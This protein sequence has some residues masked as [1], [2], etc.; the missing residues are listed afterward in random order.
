MS[1]AA[2]LE[3]RSLEASRLIEARLAGA[4]APCVTSSFQAE[5]V[6]LVHLLRQQRPEI[7][8][9]F[10]DTVHH[11]GETYAYRDQLAESWGLN[12]INLRAGEPSP[13][14]WQQDT[15]ACCARHK[16]GPLFAALDG[17]D[18][19]FT[20]LRR[21]Q[22]P[23]R[24]A[25]GEVEPF[26]LPTGRV[27]HQGQPAG[28]LVDARGVGLREAARHPAAAALRAGLHQH[29]LPAVHD[30][31]GRSGQRAVGALGG[32]EAGVRDSHP[33]TV[34]DDRTNSWRR[35]PRATRLSGRARR[36]RPASW[37]GAAGP[38]TA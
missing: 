6:V 18:A 8:V 31:A 2:T 32:P 7:P 37:P 15:T 20:G 19:W 29:R 35:R 30:A 3:A 22:S 38:G 24:A 34:A 33:G 25:L 9:L 27:L 4:A 17:Y 26:T 14:L 13:G 1:T 36:R 11:F 12:L 21:E 5:C 10:L 16:V 23:S 28:R